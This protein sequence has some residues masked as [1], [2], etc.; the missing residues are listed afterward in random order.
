MRAIWL[1]AA[2]SLVL[3]A[4]PA[5]AQTAE[6]EGPSVGEIFVTAQK[7][8]ERLQDVPITVTT[9]TASQLE[10]AGM[11]SSRDLAQVT[12]GL[13]V[14]QQTVVTQPV[15]RGVGTRG[16][17]P[18]DESTVPIYID[19][20]YSSVQHA[21]TFDL[22]NVE[23]IEVLKGPQGTLFGRNAVGGA[24][25]I[26]TRDPAPVLEGSLSASYASFNRRRGE[27]Y[28][29]SPITDNLGANLTLYASEDDGYIRDGLRGGYINP[30]TSIIGRAKL[31]WDPTANT[32]VTLALNYAQSE[33]NSGLVGRPIDGVTAGAASGVAGDY[34]AMMNN[35]PESVYFT[36]GLSVTGRHS[37]D[38]F[39]LTA[40]AS[41]QRTRQHT[42]SD[43]DASP[44]P[45]AFLTFIVGDETYTA[46]IRATSNGDG[47]LQWIV[48]GYYFNAESCYCYFNSG[49]ALLLPTQTSEAYALFGELT[50]DLTD[51][52]AVT[53]GLRYS[54]EDRAIETLRNGVFYG[55][56]EADFEQLS[57]RFTATYALS[58]TSRVYFTYS[59][60]FKSGVFNASSTALPLTAV[61]PEVLDAYEI[62]FKSEPSRAVRFNLSAYFYEHENLQVSSRSPITNATILQNAA[63]SEIYGAEA[64]LDWAVTDNFNLTA[65][66]A[67]T[68]AEFVSFP[69]AN[70]L[71]P[72]PTNLGNVSGFADVSGFAVPRTPELTFNLRGDYTA[73]LASGELTIA[74]NIYASSEYYW[75]VQNTLRSPAFVAVNG[76]VSWTS[77]DEDYVLG[78]FVENLT[79]DDRYLSVTSTSTANYGSQVRPRTVG[80]RVQ[81]NF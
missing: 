3:G 37:F 72:R 32:E 74:G 60:G 8:E 10:N 17:G 52:L 13:V 29:S 44:A 80:V 71:T 65:G 9:M 1:L 75:N 53:G 6:D 46:E 67:Y 47:P 11:G 4:T 49:S 27:L 19:G 58:D 68:H 48:G 41:Y 39:D 26:V 45:L 43:S 15:L 50:Y 62:G 69:D 59:Q 22:A 12:P 36:R 20:V 33:D 54:I 81:R 57:P 38:N 16:V 31:R 77:P 35:L 73:P 2:S 70:I 14:A 21:G 76:Q 51:R 63:S 66:L 56:G 18:G 7:R 40:L 5:F 28:L 23:R 78:L 64:Q 34:E 25:S 79:D 30:A 24:I 61:E 55:A 42:N